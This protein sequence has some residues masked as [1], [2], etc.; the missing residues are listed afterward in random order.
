M[1]KLRWSNRLSFIITASAFAVGLGNIWR[2][3]YIAGEGGGGVFLLV[4]LMMIF[5]VAMPIVL[6]E[7]ALGRMSGTTPLLGYEKLSQRPIWNGIGW[8]GITGSLLIMGYYV[9]ILAWIVFYFWESI[10]GNIAEIEVNMLSNHFDL[11]VS[12]ISIIIAIVLVIMLLAFLIIR[13]GLHSGLERYSKIMMYGLFAMLLGL[14][15]WASTLDKALEGYKWFLYPDLSKFSFS[16]IVSALGQ[17]FFS[18]G[19]GMAV[20]FVF[21][22]YTSKKENLVTSVGWIVIADTLIAILAGLMIFPALFSFDLA[23]DSGPNLIFVTM[24]SIFNDLAYG[25]WIGSIFFFLLFLAGFTSLLSAVQGIKDSLNDKFDLSVNQGLWIATGL[26]FLISI[27]VVLSYVEDPVIVFGMHTFDLLDY[28]TNNVM[29]PLGG[30]LIVIF[31]GYVI[32]FEKLV[33][34]IHHGSENI[35]IAPFWKIMLKWLI[36]IAVIVILLNGLT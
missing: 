36:P 9:M 27:P 6:I 22:S 34:H 11:V 17:L 19:V 7:M 32:G 35:T 24:A 30:F 20:S 8:L 1:A 33:T 12:N 31:A 13:R 14:A 23:P 5:T 18:V 2:F 21:G 25:S 4:Y 15:I 29:L 16:V 26:I 3:P 10:S 28:V